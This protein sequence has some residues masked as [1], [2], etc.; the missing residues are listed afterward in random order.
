MIKIIGIVVI[1]IQLLYNLE[2][3]TFTDYIHIKRFRIRGSVACM[4]DGGVPSIYRVQLLIQFSNENEYL[5]DEVDV[6]VSDGTFSL[7]GLCMIPEKFAEEKMRLLLIILEKPYIQDRL[8]RLEVFSHKEEF[9]YLIE[10]SDIC[11]LKGNKQRLF[12]A[13]DIELISNNGILHIFNLYI[14]NNAVYDVFGEV[15]E[16]TGLLIANDGGKSASLFQLKS[17][18]NRYKMITGNDQL[19]FGKESELLTYKDFV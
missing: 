4:E 15:K 3:C 16:L 8:D 14:S 12:F 13:D 9:N 19:F 11:Y 6:N 1:I 2:G 18:M 17:F 5:L 7:F 10:Y